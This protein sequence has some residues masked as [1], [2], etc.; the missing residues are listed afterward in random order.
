MSLGLSL[1]FVTLAACSSTPEEE[2][3]AGALGELVQALQTKDPVRVWAL[4]DEVSKHAVLDVVKAL[5][6]AQSKVPLVW[7]GSCPPADPNCKAAVVKEARAALGAPLIEAAGADDPGRGPRVLGFLVDLGQLTFDD[8]VMDGL[9]ARDMTF[10]EGPPRRVIV[11]TAGGDVFGFVDEGGSWRSLLVRDLVLDHPL[12]RELLANAKKT[13]GL[14]AERH[15][16]WQ[17][18]VDPKTPQGAYNVARRMVTTDPPDWKGLF[19]LLDPPAQQALGTAMEKA[20]LAQKKLQSRTTKGQRKDAY[21]DHGIALMVEATSDRDLFVRWSRTPEFV[22][23][24]TATDEPM[25]LEGDPDQG[26]ASVVTASGK[27]VPMVRDN[28]GYWRIADAE[29]AIEAALIAPAM[30]VLDGP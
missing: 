23:P 21:N 10:E 11:H 15:R 28:E 4:S 26:T 13:D 19:A 6:A 1:A 30:K 18:V 25:S 8:H 7:G 20:R 16:A 22:K 2:A 24:L 9:G 14:A 29:R 5:E 3:V 27:R 17:L 12:V